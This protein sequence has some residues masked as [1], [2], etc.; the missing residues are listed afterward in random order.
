VGCR[1]VGHRR[2]KSLRDRTLGKRA[3]RLNCALRVHG[4]IL[5]RAPGIQSVPFNKCT[6]CAKRSYFRV[7][8][9]LKC[10]IQATAS[11]QCSGSRHFQGVVFVGL[12]L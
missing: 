3:C 4:N 2:K 1:F 10:S 12:C 7:F 11:P 5:K 6:L 9:R 8:S